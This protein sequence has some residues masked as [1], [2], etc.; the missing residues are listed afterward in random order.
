MA[1]N[2]GSKLSETAKLRADSVGVATGVLLLM[3]LGGAAVH[4]QNEQA[5]R[6]SQVLLLIVAAGVA[7]LVAAASRPVDLQPRPIALGI[8]AR[9]GLRSGFRAAWFG[10][11]VLVVKAVIEV[12]GAETT[13][14]DIALRWRI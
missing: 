6:A 11:A 3:L 8:G 1:A 2:L 4:F 13:A 12:W 14:S 7:G 9:I 10:G 5:Q